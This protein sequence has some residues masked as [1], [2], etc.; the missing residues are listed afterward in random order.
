MKT[1]ELRIGNYLALPMRG[2][3]VV[4][5][6]EIFADEF[7]VCNVTSNE[8][9]IADYEPIPLTEGWISELGFEMESLTYA[10]VNCRIGF[11]EL[12]YFPTT[13]SF[14]VE[15]IKNKKLFIQYVHQLQNLYFALTGEELT[16]KQ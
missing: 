5:V 2:E 3:D 4:I 12:W 14:M 15:N 1:K 13:N 6:E 8:W 7:V 9:P 16:L 11:F 10:A